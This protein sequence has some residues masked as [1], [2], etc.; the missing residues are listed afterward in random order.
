MIT[1]LGHLLLL[2]VELVTVKTWLA[3]WFRGSTVTTK[4]LTASHKMPNLLAK[5]KC[6][7]W[8]G[9]AGTEDRHFT[10]LRDLFSPGT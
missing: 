9:H 1:S 10:L 4:H 5:F 6:P 3:K 2:R 8:G 7:E